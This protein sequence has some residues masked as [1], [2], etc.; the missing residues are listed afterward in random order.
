KIGT[1]GQVQVEVQRRGSLAC[2]GAGD[3]VACAGDHDRLYTGLGGEAQQLGGSEFAIPGRGHRVPGRQVE[4]ELE[5]FHD[6][7]YLLR[8]LGMDHAAPGGHPLHATVFEQ[9][10]MAGAVTVQHAPGDHVG[11][12]LEAAVRVVGKAGDVV[13]GLVA[14]EGVEHQEGVEPALQRLAEHAGELDAGAV[15]GRLANDQALHV[16]GTEHG[17]VRCE[18]VHGDLLDKCLARIQ[19]RRSAARRMARVILGV[20]GPAMKAAPEASGQ[21]KMKAFSHSQTKSGR[22]PR[23]NQVMKAVI[24]NAMMPAI[25]TGWTYLPCSLMARLVDQASAASM[26]ASASAKPCLTASS[27]MFRP[28]ASTE[29]MSV[30]PRK[31]STVCR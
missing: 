22:K 26:S 14:T 11:D 8:D 28:S 23:L 31:P 12:G 13:V 10:F 4:P 27:P 7:L 19:R 17:L 18:L 6:A 29:W 9:A 16:T 25:T 24:R 21:A 2:H 3:A 5:A 15:R 20:I 30:M 1:C